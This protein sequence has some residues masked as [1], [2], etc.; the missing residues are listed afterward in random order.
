MPMWHVYCLGDLGQWS[1]SGTSHNRVHT[2]PGPDPPREAHIWVSSAALG[3]GGWGQQE[4]DSPG[5]SWV[6]RRAFWWTHLIC[7]QGLPRCRLTDF[8]V[9]P[10]L[11][12]SWKEWRQHSLSLS[13]VFLLFSLWSY[14][15]WDG[16]YSIYTNKCLYCPQIAAWPV[17]V[18]LSDLRDPL[19]LI[20]HLRPVCVCMRAS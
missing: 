2:F 3:G 6:R 4:L 7:T 19:G 16:V 8:S 9:M 11:Q 15:L 20:C 1:T 17:L 12:G 10:M 14:E 18:W 5:A 13:F